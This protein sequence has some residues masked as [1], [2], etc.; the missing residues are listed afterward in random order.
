[1][2]AL[3][4]CKSLFLFSFVF[5]AFLRVGFACS[6]S[7]S[8]SF[9]QQVLNALGKE[10]RL[11]PSP[12]SSIISQLLAK[13]TQT[14]QPFLSEQPTNDTKKTVPRKQQDD[15]SRPSFVCEIANINSDSQVLLLFFF[16]D[17]VSLSSILLSVVGS[18]SRLF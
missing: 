16:F 4:P 8:L 7:G 2:A 15:D 6:V 12:H 13:Q 14:P 17:V 9:V 11:T 1:M 5:L 3:I 10:M 18:C